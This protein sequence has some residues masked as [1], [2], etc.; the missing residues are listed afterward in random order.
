MR[1]DED[2][3]GAVDRYLPSSPRGTSIGTNGV[4]D[5]RAELASPA[6]DLRG[7]VTR[8]SKIC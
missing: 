5:E 6:N 2:L 8:A 7:S 4:T 1:S 3:D